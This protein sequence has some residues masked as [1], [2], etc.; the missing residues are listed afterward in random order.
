MGD[1]LNTGYPSVPTAWQLMQQ[2]PQYNV[3]NTAHNIR[4][5]A[6]IA[7][8]RAIQ[9]YGQRTVPDLTNQAAAMGNLG[10]SGYKNKI[11]R[12]NTDLMRQNGPAGDVNRM[13][14]RNLASIAKQKMMTTIG[15]M[16]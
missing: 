6:S 7:N 9:D 3:N 5:D 8:S 1:Y 11:F 14:Y 4:E 13:M 2:T 12:A 10:S 16:F 15:A